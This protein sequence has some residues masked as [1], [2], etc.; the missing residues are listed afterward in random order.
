M[1]AFDRY[2]YAQRLFRERRY[3]AAAREL[4][5]LI[6]DKVAAVQHG[7]ERTESYT[8]GDAPLL[9]ARSYY[10]SAQLGRAEN[11]ARSLVEADPTDVYAVLLLARTLQ[12]RGR[13]AEAATW[14][15][16]LDGMGYDTWAE[17]FSPVASEE[18][19]M[20]PRPT[21]THAA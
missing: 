17:E 10:H 15:R 21:H 12:R 5:H 20:P 18:P 4:E 8:L 2:R 19:V 9:L 16:R 1:D 3:T 6:M 11:A 13:Y 7:A 14:L